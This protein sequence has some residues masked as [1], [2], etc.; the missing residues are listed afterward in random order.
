V[1]RET[2][3]L[4]ARRLVSEARVQIL[5]ASRDTFTAR[6]RGDSGLYSTMYESGVWRCGCDHRA[7]TTACSHVLAAQLVWVPGGDR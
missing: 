1:C 7:K 5:R 2:A 3:A 6:I 4:K